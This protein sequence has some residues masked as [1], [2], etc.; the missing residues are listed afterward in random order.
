MEISSLIGNGVCSQCKGC[1]K[2]DNT[3]Q[4]HPW[5]DY[6]SDCDSVREGKVHPLTCP[7]CNGSGTETFEF[8]LSPKLFNPEAV[9]DTPPP[10]G[11]DVPMPRK[12]R[13]GLCDRAHT[14]LVEA[15]D[16]LEPGED[17]IPWVH[18]AN[19]WFADHA[20]GLNR[21][22]HKC[23][24]CDMAADLLAKMN[25]LLADGRVAFP[26]G[27]LTAFNSWF[28][29]HKKTTSLDGYRLSDGNGIHWHVAAAKILWEAVY[30]LLGQTGIPASL[31]PAIKSLLASNE[32]YMNE[33]AVLNTDLT[34]LKNEKMVL[35]DECSRLRQGL[36]QEGARLAGMIKRA[37]L[38]E[39]ALAESRKTVDSLNEQLKTAPMAV[40][41]VGTEGRQLMD[42]YAV[43]KYEGESF[44][45]FVQRL[46]DQQKTKPGEGR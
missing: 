30:L 2:V 24:Q 39:N 5:S 36:A 38:A 43:G 26:G 40:L 8:V 9:L 10:E 7:K 19:A 16:A 21:D 34:K 11:G 17:D 1:G 37:S 18:K 3:W 31:V 44:T 45:A 28:H 15:H 6:P 25:D 29:N 27:M 41:A 22:L 33:A 13:C 23:A 46:V 12:P 4:H 32:K 42:L 20:M 14:I 35:D